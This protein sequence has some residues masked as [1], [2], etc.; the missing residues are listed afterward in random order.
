[1]RIAPGH[2]LLLA[3]AALW[4]ASLAAAAAQRTFTLPRET[5]TYATNELPGY[6]AGA[7]ELHRLSLRTLRGYTAPVVDARVLGR[8]GQ[9]DEE[10][11]RCGVRRRRHRPMVDYLVKTYGAE[12]PAS[13][14]GK[15]AP[16]APP[17]PGS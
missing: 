15:G 3:V 4:T 2:C 14:A 7:A 12:R 8:D 9:E 17:P 6:S 11:I 1:M 16:P 10:A 5:A 13:P